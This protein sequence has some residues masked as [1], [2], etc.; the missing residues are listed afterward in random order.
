MVL[1]SMSKMIILCFLN[2]VCPA[3]CCVSGGGE[4]GVGLRSRVRIERRRC[5]RWDIGFAREG[6][7]KKCRRTA[8][9]LRAIVQNVTF[10]FSS[11]YC[12]LVHRAVCQR[13][14]IIL[15]DEIEYSTWQGGASE[16]Q[17]G[18]LSPSERSRL[19]FWSSARAEKDITL[20][21]LWLMVANDTSTICA[22]YST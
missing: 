2:K 15:L 17:L 10:V 4:V 22:S 16:M 5:L 12:C 1:C 6:R 14:S 7:N 9:R 20:R 8:I 13:T 19:G 3:L 21:N 18:L 11:G